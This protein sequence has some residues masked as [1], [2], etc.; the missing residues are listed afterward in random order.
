MTTAFATFLENQRR[1]ER[2]FRSF[3]YSLDPTR[4]V[5]LRQ[6]IVEPASA[7]TLLAA[8]WLDE[9][10]IA[11]RLAKTTEFLDSIPHLPH[12]PRAYGLTFFQASPLGEDET[13]HQ[14]RLRIPRSLYAFKFARMQAAVGYLSCE[15]NFYGTLRGT[16]RSRRRHIH[17]LRPYTSLGES[18]HSR[19]RERN[20]RWR[21]KPAIVGYRIPDYPSILGVSAA[22]ATEYVA[23]SVCHEIGHMFLPTTPRE[24][25]SV[26]NIAML[27]AMGARQDRPAADP[28]E[29]LILAEC[30]DPFFALDPIVA[31][32]KIAA[33]NG[34]TLTGIQRWAVKRYEQMYTS[35]KAQ[36]N[37]D[38]HWG[39]PLAHSDEERTAKMLD[40]IAQLRNTGFQ[41]YLDVA[42]KPEP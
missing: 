25:E 31:Y 6:L 8:P 34:L 39:S 11:A 21:Q 5:T 33:C 28:W 18:A 37:R 40:R 22:T 9:E 1:L 36:A 20:A 41:I 35:K 12:V 2:R 13:E 32:E 7:Q 4:T 15:T 42:K 38:T 10:L 29:D 3:L 24:V 19:N 16:W 26:H 17:P 27:H 23:R 30:T 14:E